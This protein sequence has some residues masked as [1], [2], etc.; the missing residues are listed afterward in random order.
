MPCLIEAARIAANNSMQDAVVHSRGCVQGL[1]VASLCRQQNDRGPTDVRRA[2]HPALTEF[3]VTKEDQIEYDP[4]PL[5]IEGD[6][7]AER[8]EALQRSIEW[9]RAALFAPTHPQAERVA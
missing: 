8:I 2:D 5:P 7:L 3:T 1:T 9:R 6:E 4:D